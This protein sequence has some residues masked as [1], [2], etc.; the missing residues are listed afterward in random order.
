MKKLFTLL[1][2]L[3]LG[4][5]GMWAEDVVPRT[6]LADGAY[7]INVKDTKIFYDASKSNLQREDSYRRQGIFTLKKG[8]GAYSSCYTI[9]IDGKHVTYSSTS[10]NNL[11][12]STSS[13]ATNSNKWW[14]IA[15]YKNDESTGKLAI[16]PYQA[17]IATSNDAWNLAKSV[18][19]NANQAV[20]FWNGTDNGSYVNLYK[21]EEIK[22]S[23]EPT[24]T[25]AANTTWYTIKNHTAGNYLHDNGNETKISLNRTSTSYSAKDLF[26]FVG[27]SEHGYKIYNMAA[28]VNKILSSSETMGSAFSSGTYDGPWPV[29]T[30]LTN[31]NVP[32]GYNTTWDLTKGETIS[33]EIG[34]LFTQHGTTNHTLNDRG[35]LGYWNGSGNG[36]TMRIA[37]VTFA[38]LVEYANN[39]LEGEH[40]GYVGFHTNAANNTLQAAVTTAEATET[41]SE[42]DYETL[43]GA[44]ETFT[45]SP[46][47][48]L[49]EG[50]YYRFVSASTSKPGYVVSANSDNKLIWEAEDDLDEKQFWKVTWLNDN[51]IEA[52]FMNVG[53]NLY[54]QEKTADSEQFAL[55]SDATNTNIVALGSAQYNIKPNNQKSMHVGG[56]NT[57]NTTGNIVSWNNTV[58][59]D[60]SAWYISEIEKYDI[61]IT[62]NDASGRIIINGN[63]FA[64]GSKFYCQKGKEFTPVAKSITDYKAGAVSISDNTI[65]V[66]YTEAATVN[67]NV[68]YRYKADGASE[69]TELTRSV[70]TA[71]QNEES[72]I[73]LTLTT[74]QSNPF[75]SA[76]FVVG[77]SET[78]LTLPALGSGSVYEETKNI[79]ITNAC[80]VYVNLELRPLPTTGK[81][82]R[83]YNVNNS[84]HW[85]YNNGTRLGV[86]ANRKSDK[87]DMFY[88]LETGTSGVYKFVSALNGYG[89]N[90]VTWQNRTN[91]VK[92]ERT[93]RITFDRYSTG[94]EF[95]IHIAQNG[96]SGTLHYLHANGDDDGH[97][98]VV[99][100]EASNSRWYA[101]EVPI[102]EVADPELEIAKIEANRILNKRGVGYP[103]TSSSAYSALNTA[104]NANNATVESI[105]TAVTTYK[106][107]TTA[108]DIQM[109]EDG[110]TYTITA[111]AKDDTKRFYMKYA[112]SGYT[113]NATTGLN[114]GSYPNTTYLTCKKIGE[115]Y[116]F[117]NNDGKYFIFKGSDA[118]AN[119]NK[120][121]LDEYNS[122]HNFTVSRML[123]TSNCTSENDEYIGYV[124][125]VGLRNNNSDG[126]FVHKPGGG[127]DQASVPFFNDNFSSALVLDEVVSHTLSLAAKKSL[128]KIDIA[129]SG[130]TFAEGLGNYH[131]VA[132]EVIS[133]DANSSISEATTNA[134]VDAI[135]SSAAINMP[136]NGFYRFTSQNN[137]HQ[138]GN[139][140]K[141]LHNSLYNGGLAL[142]T[143]KDETTI[144]YVDCE[145][146]RILSYADGKYLY[147]W[148]QAPTVGNSGTWTIMEGS[149]IG[150][151]AIK[152]GSSNWYASDW[153]T[154]DHITNGNKDANALW[155]I[156]AVDELPLTLS[157]GGYTS[158][159]APVP[160]V[161]PED[162]GEDKADYYAYYATSQANDAGV[163]NMRRVTGN[164]PAYTGLIIYTKIDNP[165]I[166][167]AENSTSLEYTNLLSA[168]VAA[169]NIS[170]TDNYFF[171][172]VSGKYVFTKLSG[173]DDYLLP[174]HKAYL[175]LSS[176]GAR[177]SINWGVDDPTGLSELRDE[178]IKLSDGKYYQNGRVVI[179]R[180][181][182]KYNVAGQ[183]I[184]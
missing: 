91:P 139:V 68:I 1:T 146:N 104:I 152:I 7:F 111:V 114:D 118:G 171:G 36:S 181:G 84:M 145:N 94:G 166:Q 177:M 137:S 163:I 23:D 67:V 52:T 126:C 72:T 25:F 61:E 157:E 43:V 141:Y 44:M 28:G 95:S 144:F 15:N 158:F 26:C 148:D 45:S 159:S 147:Y 69:Y 70:Q 119:D 167:I 174:G 117:V 13:D 105:N 116:A 125:M 73:L 115:K 150:K 180:N 47:V 60:P 176:G 103:T 184:K 49:V 100:E 4:I 12:F 59:G 107:V 9:Q 155:A 169:A 178:N 109:P 143:T 5:S 21:I 162:N 33:G 112:S 151:Y 135:L 57:S 129:E 130:K 29:M 66:T 80:D 134:E 76:T 138:K 156:E 93:G 149:E 62:G 87:S 42:T 37:E 18:G 78:A 90:E 77:E 168:N 74:A 16:Y 170:K 14:V 110:K 182:V 34:F 133:Y 132:G 63:E 86:T 172:K 82:Y 56:W 27:D 71:V 3:I 98:V 58:I 83:F 165:T 154:T 164:V 179:V 32:D 101:E 51:K 53:T 108:T 183:T 8:T 19:G 89:Y 65:S 161:I 102:S 127:Y 22:V 75:K 131:V 123:K 39:L 48:T 38:D 2:M 113:L 24:I 40:A 92:F 30:Q 173:D 122:S 6:D 97:V 54:P 31:G 128:A 46:T 124:Y 99:W 10:G 142:N 55:G 88:L 11:T 35:G 17:S 81:L 160:I 136:A 121:Y 96:K 41:P 175:N 140:G 79:T 50:K 20:G 120:G 106:S 153:N 85:M 64:N